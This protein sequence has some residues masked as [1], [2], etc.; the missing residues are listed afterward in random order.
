MTSSTAV[1]LEK[2]PHYH[3]LAQLGQQCS[4]TCTSRKWVNAVE[5]LSFD[6]TRTT[7]EKL[8]KARNERSKKRIGNEALPAAIAIDARTERARLHSQRSDG[9]QQDTVTFGQPHQRCYFDTCQSGSSARP[10]FYHF[11]NCSGGKVQV[12][13]AQYP[14]LE[15]DAVVDDKGDER[16]GRL[17]HVGH[18]PANAEAGSRVQ[19]RRS[20]CSAT[21]RPSSQLSTLKQTIEFARPTA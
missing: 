7:L 14:S 19:G 5:V 17:E 10:R 21:S 11:T 20:E 15:P 3:L 18:E 2:I 13:G 16:H 12:A 6:I 9:D 4:C 1:H 8:E